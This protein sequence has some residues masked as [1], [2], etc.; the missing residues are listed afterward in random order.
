MSHVQGNCTHLRLYDLEI[1]NLYPARR[2]VRNLEL[3]LDGSLGLAAADAAHAAAEAA[4][5]AA[6][7]VVVA[8]DGRQAELG[9]HEELLG[10]AEL[11]D[12]P[13]DGR[14]LRRVVHG[15]DVGPEAGRVG[16]VRDGDDDGD[17]VGRRPALELRSRL[18]RGRQPGRKGGRWTRTL[19]MYS[20]LLP[21]WLSTTHST[22][23]SGLTC[24]F[25]R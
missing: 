6:A 5:H 21:E 24:V 14:R 3:D 4:H 22:Q 7:L 15:A 8:P 1:A 2:E 10:A 9:A 18:W 12:L 13:D 16:V 25:R 20:I 23:I 11:L 17:V 19:S